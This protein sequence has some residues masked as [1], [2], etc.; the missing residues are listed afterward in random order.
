MEV[1]VGHWKAAMC[2]LAEVGPQDA[3]LESC[4]GGV[5]CFDVGVADRLGMVQEQTAAP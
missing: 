2:T 3:V 5:A 4:L 1:L